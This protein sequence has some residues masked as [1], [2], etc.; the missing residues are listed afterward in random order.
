MAALVPLGQ[1]AGGHGLLEASLT[2][3][4]VRPSW[5]PPPSGDANS[6]P[7]AKGGGVRRTFYQTKARELQVLNAYVRMSQQIR[8]VIGG[9]EH[10]LRHG[11]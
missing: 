11:A 5:S 6:Y 3:R 7:L 8:L 9:I 1:E 2:K 4:G 10:R